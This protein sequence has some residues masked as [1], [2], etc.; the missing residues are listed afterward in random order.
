MTKDGNGNVNTEGNNSKESHN[1]S[2]E[3]QFLLSLNIKD[4]EKEID[5][6]DL[7]Y[8][9]DEFDEND[10]DEYNTSA[11]NDEYENS[12]TGNLISEKEV[13]DASFYGDSSLTF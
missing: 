3:L 6:D 12:E 8:W 7:D 10:T 13:Q 1:D 9:T 4:A 11:V 2:D 5:E